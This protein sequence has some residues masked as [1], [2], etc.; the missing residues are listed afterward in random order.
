MIQDLDTWKQLWGK[1]IPIQFYL[2]KQGKAQINNLNLYLKYP[3]R[4]KAAA[5]SKVRRKE[6]IKIREEIN[7][8]EMNKTMKNINEIKNWFFESINKIDKTLLDSYG[9]T[10]GHKSMKLE[11]QREMLQWT[12][13][14]Y[15]K[16]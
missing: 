7:E 12:P 13:Q 15:K 5:E 2:R 3:E 1:F 9:K 6:I 14:K 11:M 10:R 16:S 4:K 8:S